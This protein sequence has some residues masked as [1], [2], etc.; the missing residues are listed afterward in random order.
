MPSLCAANGDPYCD[1]N[2][3]PF[4]NMNNA[5]MG[6]DIV[7]GDRLARDGDPGFRSQIFGAV[8][9][10]KQGRMVLDDGISAI[11]LLECESN[12]DSKTVTNVAEF[13]EELS[14]SYEI[15][16][17]VSGSYGGYSGN[18]GYKDNGSSKQAKEKLQSGETAIM[19]SEVECQLHKLRLNAELL[20][21]FTNQFIAALKELAA[22]STSSPLGTRQK[23]FFKFWRDYGTH[24]ITESRFGAK[25]VIETEFSKTETS[26]RQLKE[27]ERCRGMSMGFSAPFMSG[28]ASANGCASS[29]SDSK[30]ANSNAR[31][32]SQIISIGSKPGED[33]KGLI[34]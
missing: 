24:Y 8:V 17:D 31:S 15:S 2:W 12:F 22:V 7:D 21:G 27:Q 25:L 6:Y 10:D 3:T 14:S 26:E 29:S 19:L 16:A 30:S 4:A 9:V 34:V 28:E 11:D 23:V 18:F 1:P 32:L 33:A 5:L 20:P 13:K